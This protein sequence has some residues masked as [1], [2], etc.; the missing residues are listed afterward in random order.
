MDENHNQPVK[1]RKEMKVG[2]WHEIFSTVQY[3]AKYTT[4]DENFA[5]D[6]LCVIVCLS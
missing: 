3:D 4:D 1:E 6:W 5:Y 2:M